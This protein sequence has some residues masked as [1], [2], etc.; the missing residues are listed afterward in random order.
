[1]AFKADYTI[2]FRGTLSSISLLKVSQVFQEMKPDQI[3]EICGA[4]PATR[5][6]LFRVLPQAAY[7]LVTADGDDAQ[8]D[9]CR[10]QLK[11]KECCQ[12]NDD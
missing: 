7:Q 8:D 4:D 10:L 11:K 1:V 5:Q 2:D 3:M 9:I 12:E 6:D